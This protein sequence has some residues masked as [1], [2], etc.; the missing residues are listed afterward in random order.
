CALPAPR[1]RP[2]VPWALPSVRPL[3]AAGAARPAAAVARAAVPAA[4]SAAGFATRA[5][6]PPIRAAG[7]RNRGN[8]AACRAGGVPCWRRAVLAGVDRGVVSAERRMRRRIGPVVLPRLRCSLL[9]DLRSSPSARCPQRG[10]RTPCGV[11]R[12]LPSGHGQQTT[13][14]EPSSC[15][16]HREPGRGAAAAGL[17]PSGA[18]TDG[19]ERAQAPLRGVRAGPPVVLHPPRCSGGSAG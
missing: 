1:V 19:G 15:R 3:L 14:R 8:G 10:T 13:G 18:A 5:S 12:A 2:S 4:V 9:G 11:R 6:V 16:L 17:H 7:G